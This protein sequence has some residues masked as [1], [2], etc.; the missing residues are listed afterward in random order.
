[1]YEIGQS[2]L[3]VRPEYPET[4]HGGTIFRLP[5]GNDPAYTVRLSDGS[6]HRAMLPSLTTDPAAAEAIQ[7]LALLERANYFEAKAANYR[8]LA[9]GPAPADAP[10]EDAA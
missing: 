2:V 4:I 8:A 5:D 10:P 6:V 9:A 3:L 1:M 7:R